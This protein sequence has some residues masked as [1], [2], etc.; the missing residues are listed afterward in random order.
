MKLEEGTRSLF[1]HELI[2]SDGDGR[3]F[4]GLD[5]VQILLKSLV[6]IIL[7]QD[8]WG[9]LVLRWLRWR[10]CYRVRLGASVHKR[11][12]RTWPTGMAWAKRRVG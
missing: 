3:L 4:S 12:G 9:W 6:G 5:G 2:R 1:Y 8:H 10:R 7:V 11:R